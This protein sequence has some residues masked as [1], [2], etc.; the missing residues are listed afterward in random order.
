MILNPFK[1]KKCGE[2]LQPENLLVGTSPDGKLTRKCGFCGFEEVVEKD[3]KTL[4]DIEE[5]CEKLDMMDYTA[6]SDI[7]IL[8]Q[9]T[10]IGFKR[11]KEEAIKI[12]K[13]IND[14]SNKGILHQ[15]FK[16]ISG[17]KLNV[18][19]FMKWFFNISKEDLK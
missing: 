16:K 5:D 6:P 1:C 13:R 4:K 2:E 9:G 10:K 8:R 18:D 12:K 11:A 3:L 19:T 14:W 7:N 15:E 17:K